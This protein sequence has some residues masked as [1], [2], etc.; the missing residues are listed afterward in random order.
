MRRDGEPE[1]LTSVGCQFDRR[2]DVRAQQHIRSV[3]TRKTRGVR[4]HG[5]SQHGEDPLATT[6]EPSGDN[7]KLYI[8]AKEGK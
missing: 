5:P 2:L 3:P 6:A 4:S 7:R 1:E 8:E